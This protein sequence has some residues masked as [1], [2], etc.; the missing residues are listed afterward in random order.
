MQFMVMTQ[1]YSD[2]YSEE[3]FASVLPEE[4]ETVRKLYAEG[5]V[6]QIWLRADGPGAC[7]L[8]EAASL[9]EAQAAVDAL[10][11]AREQ[12]SE[13]RIIPLRPYGGFGP[14]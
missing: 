10:P 4:T 2:Q 11:L 5:V 13:F 7:F 3:E 9:E 6:R 1:R 12:M 8:L 14:R